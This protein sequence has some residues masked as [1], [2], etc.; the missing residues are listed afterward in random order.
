MDMILKNYRKFQMRR[1]NVGTVELSKHQLEKKFA[2]KNNG[3]TK[4]GVNGKD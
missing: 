1:E 3:S 4:I 2:V